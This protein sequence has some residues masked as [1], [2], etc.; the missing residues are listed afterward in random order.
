MKKGFL[1]PAMLCA[2]FTCQANDYFFKPVFSATERYYSNLFLRTV[3]VQ[4]N[5][6]STLSPGLNFGLRHENGELKSNFTWNQLFYTNQSALNVSEQLFSLAYNHNSE[7]LQWGTS[8]YYNN[9]ASTNT[10]GTV[11]GPTFTQVMA[12]QLYLAPTATYSLTELSSLTVNYSYN[13]TTYDKTQ[14]IFL[15][16]YDY[17]QAS[18]T[19][20]HLYTEN[21]KLNATLSSS[22]YKSPTRGLTTFNNVAQLGWQHSFD[23][24]LVTYLSAG[25]NYSVSE[26]QL[27]VGQ[28][29]LLFF[30][31]GRPYYRDPVD[32]SP[33]PQQQYQT[34]NLSKS[35]F[36]QVYQASI[37]KTFEKGSASL[38]GSQ[39]QTPTSQGLQTQSQLTINTA[40]IINERWTSNLTANYSIYELTGVKNSGLNRNSAS[41]SPTINWKWTPE[42]NVGLSYTYRQQEYKSSSQVSQ[43]NSV[44][45]Q[46]NYQPQTNSQVK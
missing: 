3:P 38:V 26:T 37:Q 29:P 35:G 28:L 19:F 41:V 21:D 39:N 27:T 25:M 43:D 13:K 23:K 24:Q 16:D 12:K 17:H 33:T 42:I 44:Q 22:R 20:N 15:S 36:G 45:L 14:N 4:D 32:G 9:Q 40:Y 10:Q 5:W 8:G 18:G 30:F 11:L 34:V 6:I 31:Q 2:S 7:R 46:F 1:V